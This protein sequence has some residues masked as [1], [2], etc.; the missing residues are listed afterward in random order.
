[1][2]K[3]PLQP[4]FKPYN[5]AN[6]AYHYPNNDNFI[7]REIYINPDLGGS[8]NTILEA[9]SIKQKHS[10]LESYKVPVANYSV[11][12]PNEI[13]K[14]LFFV[15]NIAGNTYEDSDFD[16]MDQKTQIGAV[17]LTDNLY[18][19]LEDKIVSGESY[20]GD[21]F[22]LHQ[23]VF[24]DN[25]VPTLVDLE[26]CST[27]SRDAKLFKFE[28]EALHISMFTKMAL[29]IS[30]N[31]PELYQL[32]KNRSINLFKMSCTYNGVIANDKLIN[33]CFD[34]F[35]SDENYEI[36][37]YTSKTLHLPKNELVRMQGIK[38]LRSHLNKQVDTAKIAI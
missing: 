5:P 9:Q 4:G 10:N 38:N 24:N 18:S 37:S 27:L 8:K 13:G 32:W 23:Y 21:I 16:K 22:A 1:M 26:P 17:N 34:N 14:L 2:D 7:I 11:V 19:Y 20:L 33:E 29:S 31:N 12:I 3:L 15:D 35:L 36:S 25:G 30:K 28:T 6:E